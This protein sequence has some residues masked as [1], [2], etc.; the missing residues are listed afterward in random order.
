M[1]RFLL[2]ALLMSS[3]ASAT[4]S[5]ALDT[6]LAVIVEA[7]VR[8]TGLSIN[9]SQTTTYSVNIDK[10]DGKNVCDPAAASEVKRFQDALNDQPNIKEN[11]GPA[12]FSLTSLDGTRKVVAPEQLKKQGTLKGCT[13]IYVSV[14]PK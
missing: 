6:R 10:I 7:A 1:N 11:Y 8:A 5:P 4:D 3:V 14:S 2:A 13:N 12:Y 9:I